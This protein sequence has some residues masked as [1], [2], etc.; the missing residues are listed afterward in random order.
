MTITIEQFVE[1]EVIYCASLLIGVLLTAASQHG[2][3]DD[4]TDYDE[5]LDLTEVRDYKEPAQDHIAQMNNAELKS[6][7][8]DRGVDDPRDQDVIDAV[9]HEMFGADADSSEA[10]DFFGMGQSELANLLEDHLEEKDGWENFCNNN[11]LEPHTSE[12]YEHWIVSRWLADKLKAKGEAVNTNICGLVI[13]GRTT[14]GQAISMDW[15]IGKIYE[16]LVN[17]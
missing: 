8:S 10:E 11:D 17:D 6:A 14:T 1:R 15:V 9:V 4:G 7:L 13:W 16:E 5:L 3:L 2:R 12:V